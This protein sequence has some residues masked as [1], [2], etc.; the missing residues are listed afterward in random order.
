V[1]GGGDEEIGVGG[2]E[3]TERRM[4]GGG[5]MWGDKRGMEGGVLGKETEWR[6]IGMSVGTEGGE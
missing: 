4:G 1:G 3:G 5:S 6:E 2:G